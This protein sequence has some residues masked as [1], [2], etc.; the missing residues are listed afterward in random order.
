MFRIALCDDN[1]QFIKFENEI[2]QD[3]FLS[4]GENCSIDSYNCGADLIKDDNKLANYNLILL[5]CEMPGISGLEA[6]EVIREKGI[7]VP[8]AF[9]T[10]YYDFTIKGYHYGLVRYLVKTEDS[11][12]DNIIECIKY[13]KSIKKENEYLSIKVNGVMQTY[14]QSDIVWIT[15]DKHYIKLFVKNEAEDTWNCSEIKVRMKLEDITDSLSSAF[16]R[17]HNRNIVNMDYI[18]EFSPYFVVLNT[19][20]QTKTNISMTVRNKRDLHKKYYAYKGSLL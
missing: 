11:F 14:K 17:V 2:I 12:R 5:D 20:S 4:S 6:A 15:S 3:Y 7:N 19:S 13:V 9:S 1:E 18:S 8:I 10:N 16:L